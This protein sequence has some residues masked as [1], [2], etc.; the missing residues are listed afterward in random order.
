MFKINYFAD[1][2]RSFRIEI[3]WHDGRRS[4][5]ESAGSMD[6]MIRLN[7]YYP[8]HASSAIWVHLSKKSIMENNL[9]AKASGL[10]TSVT[11]R[12]GKKLN[13]IILSEMK[14]DLK[15]VISTELVSLIRYLD[16]KYEK[17]F[18]VKPRKAVDS[19][20]AA[21]FKLDRTR[22]QAVSACM[23]EDNREWT[24]TE[25]KRLLRMGVNDFYQR[26]LEVPG[27]LLQPEFRPDTPRALDWR[28]FAWNPTLRSVRC[29][30]PYFP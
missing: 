28:F 14:E 10:N 20:A 9:G 26:A 27:R 13:G 16:G 25:L 17:E 23:D 29:T 22:V 30:C 1:L 3:A 18:G 21:P 4:T 19:D 7:K 5:L 12:V 8:L 6:L 15:S 2:T 11:V 24:V